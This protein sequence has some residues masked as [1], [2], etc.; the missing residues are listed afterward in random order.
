MR[1]AFCK[2]DETLDAAGER[3]RKLRIREIVTSTLP[4]S[5]TL[6]RLRRAARAPSKVRRYKNLLTNRLIP[7]SSI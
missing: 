5:E 1:F 2:R 3:L 7:T 4:S 6:S